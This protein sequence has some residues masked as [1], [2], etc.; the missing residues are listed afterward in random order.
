[1]LSGETNLLIQEGSDIKVGG[2]P[3]A[4]EREFKFMEEK[5]EEV[6]RM[7]AGLNVTDADLDELRNRLEEVRWVPSSNK[8][9]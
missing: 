4:F 8:R 2:A 3:G 1:M 5:L 7:V 9:P 6:K